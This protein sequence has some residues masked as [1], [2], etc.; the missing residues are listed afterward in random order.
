MNNELFVL[1]F[2]SVYCCYLIDSEVEVL[3]LFLFI[4]PSP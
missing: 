1:L 4:H 2:M 3:F